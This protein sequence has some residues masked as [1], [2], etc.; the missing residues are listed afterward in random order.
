[1]INSKYLVATY[2]TI[3]ERNHFG[4]LCLANDRVIFNYGIKR[5]FSEK[6]GT[7]FATVRKVLPW[8][9]SFTKIC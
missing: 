5:G 8:C 7:F 6:F 2:F 3:L 1:M 9:V 4:K